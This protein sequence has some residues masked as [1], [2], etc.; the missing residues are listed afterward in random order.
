[1]C[2]AL[3]A[4]GAGDESDLAFNTSSHFEPQFVVGG[5][6]FTDDGRH[7]VPAAHRRRRRE[8]GVGQVDLP[9][10]EPLEDLLQRN[11]ALEPG[12]RRAEAVV[13]ADAEREVLA[14]FAVDVEDVAVGREL[15]VVAH[16]GADEHHHHAALRHRLAVDTRRRG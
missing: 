11:A 15:A 12:Q 8:R 9:L 5:E 14:V 13:R 10:G 7:G 16:R 1:M 2:A 3:T 6:D 4:G